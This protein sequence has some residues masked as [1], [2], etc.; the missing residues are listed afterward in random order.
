MIRHLAEFIK[1]SGSQI[2]NDL[3]RLPSRASAVDNDEACLT[4]CTAWYTWNQRIMGLLERTNPR[5]TWRSV[6]WRAV[7][8]A[9]FGAVVFFPAFK[10]AL[11]EAWLV[12]LPI[13]C[14]LCAFVGGLVEWQV[15]DEADECSGKDDP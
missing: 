6:V 10:P 2:L 7:Q 5:A 11:R 13:W 12:T 9:A 15:G 14:L 3:R 1:A 4:G 8:A